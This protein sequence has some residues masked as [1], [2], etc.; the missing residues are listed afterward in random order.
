M[1]KSI[2]L[3]GFVIGFLLIGAFQNCAGPG[4]LAFEDLEM[5]SKASFFDYP[6]K[7]RP[8]FFGDI[9]IFKADANVENLDSFIFVGMAS[10]LPDENA[11]VSYVIRITDASGN[12]LCAS[13]Q[14]TLN[15]G[16]SHIRF[17]CLTNRSSPSVKIRMTLTAGSDSTNIER[18]YSR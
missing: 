16:E 13:Q 6:Y 18:E 4:D 5:T 3:R 17:D 2:W 8:L 12:V 1:K 9:Q 11:A 15:S 14:G 10:Y 7:T